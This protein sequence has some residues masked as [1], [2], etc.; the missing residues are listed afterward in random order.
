MLKRFVG[1]WRTKKVIF[2]DPDNEFATIEKVV[3]EAYR[4][5]VAA[6]FYITG[7]PAENKWLSVWPVTQALGMMMQFHSLFLFALRYACKVQGSEV[8]DAARVADDQLIG[9]LSSASWHR[10][11]RTRELKAF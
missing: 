9:A 4:L 11:E 2:W 6:G 10:R 8:E 3:D 5:L 7:T 1:D